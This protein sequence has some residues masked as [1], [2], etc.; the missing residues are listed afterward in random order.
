[1]AGRVGVFVPAAGT[2][3]HSDVRVS[4]DAVFVMA[5]RFRGLGEHAR[6]GIS[7]MLA[8][9]ALRSGEFERET[10]FGRARL[11][12]LPVA[13]AFADS[14]TRDS[15]FPWRP[16]RTADDFWPDDC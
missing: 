4:P 13:A 3:A 15:R 6:Y 7:S 12:V 9:A 16:S 8:P 10:L 11:C 2:P 14:Q 5:V 1:M